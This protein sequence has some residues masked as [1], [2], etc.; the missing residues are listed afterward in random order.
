MT[1]D[2]K[3]EERKAIQLEVKARQELLRRL[4]HPIKLLKVAGEKERIRREERVTQ[5]HEY[6][7]IDEA[8][9]AYGWGYLSDDEYHAIKEAIESGEEYIENTI[10]PVELAAKILIDFTSRISSEIRSLEF[11]LLPL[12]E[13]IMRMEA[14]EK[15]REE[16]AERK[17]ARGRSEG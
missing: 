15:R 3:E 11:E 6:K 5:A 10:S 7:T 13:Q 9:E 2:Q 8:Q 17:A 1:T 12:E 16:I 14:A 4:E